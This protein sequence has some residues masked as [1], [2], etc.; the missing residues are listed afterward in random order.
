MDQVYLKSLL[1]QSNKYYQHISKL[2]F[3]CC[4]LSLK[5]LLLREVGEKFI[6]VHRNIKVVSCMS[7]IA[8]SVIVQ[9]RDLTPTSLST[10]KSINLWYKVGSLKLFLKC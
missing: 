4:R 9:M 6:A 5:E 7:Y 2:Y 8:L 10:G 3:K 1:R